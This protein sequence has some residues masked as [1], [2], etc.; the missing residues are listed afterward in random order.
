MRSTIRNLKHNKAAGCD[1]IPAEL[2]QA[3]ADHTAYVPQHI[4]KEIW[5]TN[6]IPNEWNTGLI[7]K[8][9]KKGDL[10]YC[11]NWRRLRY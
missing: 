5:R 2:L 4:M 10:K 1:G 7:I 3:E 6:D 9:P 8:L 11:E